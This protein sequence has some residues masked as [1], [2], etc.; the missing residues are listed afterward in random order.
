MSERID[1]LGINNM[2][3]IQNDEYFC[4]GMD[5]ILLANFVKSNSSKNIIVDF[6][7]GSGVIPIIVSAKNKYKKIYAVELQ[8]EMFD[9]LN[10]N[11]LKNNLADS[12]IP[13][14]EDIRN[15]NSI[16]NVISENIDIIVCNPPYKE[17]GTGI[18]NENKVKYI[19]RHEEKCKLSD[20]FENANKLL[21]VKGELYLVHK[22]ERLADLINIA[23]QYNLEPKIIKFVYPRVDLK[24]SIVLIKYVKKGG[25]ELVVEKP[26]IEYTDSGEYTEE[27]YNLYGISR[28]IG[29]WWKIIKEFY[30]LSALQLE[31]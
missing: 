9:L 13:I 31:I 19:A 27:I 8:N 15:V 12:I 26:L 17:V 5:S 29:K 14:N 10:R 24:P 18:I 4:F 2:S 20:I 11:I 30:M 16:K 1:E 6:C 21:N 3:I 7:S 22:P 23:R 28:E 25:N